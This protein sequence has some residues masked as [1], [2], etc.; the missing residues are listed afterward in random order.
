[1]GTPYQLHVETETRIMPSALDEA[2]RRWIRRT[3]R[4][5]DSMLPANG[6]QRWVRIVSV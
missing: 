1:M 5:G 6:Y 2:R 3:F 4:E